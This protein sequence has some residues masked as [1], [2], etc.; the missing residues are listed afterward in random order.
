MLPLLWV[1]LHISKV[2]SSIV[3][4]HLSDLMGRRPLI[5]SGWIVYALVYAGFAFV[6]SAWDAWVLFIIYGTYFGLTE[7]T[8]KA[9]VADMVG[10]EKRG[11]AYGL[12]NLAYGI[13][14]LPASLLF[15]LAWDRFGAP[16]AFLASAGV[17]VLSAALL[18]SLKIKK[19]GRHRPSE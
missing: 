11:T 17:S 7:G 3:G 9:L 19:D 2:V 16:T 4:G 12:Y 13:T 14:V 18:I 1:V 5:V 8:E 15:G 6:G 10:E